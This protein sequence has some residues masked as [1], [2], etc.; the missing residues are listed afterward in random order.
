MSYSK[1]YAPP[2][3]AGGSRSLNKTSA[4]D[5]RE[6]KNN[7]AS[8]IRQGSTAT[9]GGGRSMRPGVDSS[10][11]MR[12]DSYFSRASGDISGRPNSSR[13]GANYG[14]PGGAN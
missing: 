10:G 1:T 9:A 5:K 7:I 13:K 2:S 4:K 3:S 8:F 12:Q 11:F 6:S 14:A